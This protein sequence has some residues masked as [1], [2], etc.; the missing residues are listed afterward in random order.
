MSLSVCCFAHGPGQRVAASLGPLREV[1]DEIVVAVDSR[2]DPGLLGDYERIADVLLRFEFDFLERH[3]GWLHARCSSDWILRLDSD[4]LPSRA[5]I[6][7][8]PELTRSGVQQFWLPRRWSFPTVDTWLDELPWWPDYQNRLVR[9]GAALYFPGTLHSNAAPAEPSRRIEAPIYHLDCALTGEQERR[10]KALIYE[11]R[12]P[13]HVAPGGGPLNFTYYVPERSATREPAPAAAEDLAALHEYVR[14]GEAAP[15]RSRRAPAEVAWLD[16]SDRYWAARPIAADQYRARIEPIEDDLDMYTGELRP[17]HCRLTNDSDRTWFRWDP[18]REPGRQV[19]ASY[20]WL[21]TDRSVYELDGERSELP[22]DVAPG[23]SI[24]LGVTVRAPERPG[25]YLIELDLVHEDWFGCTRRL[26]VSVRAGSLKPTGRPAPASAKRSGLRRRSAATTDLRIPRVIH[27][28]WVGDNPMP[29]DFR[30]YGES[31]RRHHP[32]WE[33][34]LW[35]RAEVAELVPADLIEQA[36]SAAEVSD[37]ARYFALRDHGGVY[38]DTD[39]ECLRPIEPLLDGVDAFAGYEVPGR[40]GSAVI[41]SVPEHPLFAL[42]AQRAPD[43]VG[44]F[45]EPVATGPV[46]LT[47]IA[48]EVEGLTLY[49]PSV[50]YPYRWDEPERRNESFPG[51]Y[52]VHHWAKSWA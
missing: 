51:S 17:L 31:W 29:D 19:R 2:T 3:L 23:E 24:V 52:A 49:E 47:T 10:R 27:R 45:P 36:R 38:V 48:Y 6:E 8:L 15:L 32:D 11:L 33:M 13:G 12:R 26:P 22:I 37:L 21:L 28:V 44:R 1:A 42:A 39:V 30:R 25:D 40:L 20:H 16:E 35:S 46:F 41:G 34:R 43:V 5:L 4:E 50:F 7:Q 18:Q 9:N 14:A